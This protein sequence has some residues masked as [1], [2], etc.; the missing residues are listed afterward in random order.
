MKLIVIIFVGTLCSMPHKKPLDT[1][2]R[3][4]SAIP[5]LYPT[6]EDLLKMADKEISSFLREGS[7][8]IGRA[9]K[10][11][12]AWFI[13]KKLILQMGQLELQKEYIETIDVLVE[14]IKIKLRESASL[15]TSLP[16]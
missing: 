16:H 7:C 5:I 10:I 8:H 2:I 1:S 11:L 13:T 6:S 14:R 12:R 3:I 9:T 15:T 4:L